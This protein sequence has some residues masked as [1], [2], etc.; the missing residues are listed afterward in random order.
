VAGAETA[1][2]DDETGGIERE[3]GVAVAA[4]TDLTYSISSSAIS[5][6]KGVSMSD[7]S[8]S[9]SSESRV[10]YDFEAFRLNLSSSSNVASSC[11]A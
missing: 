5:R 11:G 1:A 7:S 6:L 4:S 8:E 3:D 10:R 2:R 9:R